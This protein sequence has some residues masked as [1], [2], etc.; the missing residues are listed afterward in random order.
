MPRDE[1]PALYLH[2]L[3][4]GAYSSIASTSLFDILA[5][6][7]DG[8]LWVGT[9]FASDAWQSVTT[10]RN[11]GS[12]WWRPEVGDGSVVRFS[13]GHGDLDAGGHWGPLRVVYLQYPSDPIVFF[14]PDM[15]WR[16]PVWLSGA[17]AEGVSSLLNWYPVVTFLQLALD[18]ALAQTTPIGFGHVYAPQDYFDGWVAVTGNGGLSA[19]EVASL[20]SLLSR[21]GERERI[22]GGWVRQNTAN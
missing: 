3:S 1:R 14:E 17:R 13:N 2:G 18:M 8:A 16:E 22:N 7:F 15:L 9:P 5:D 19:S 4:L 20:R 12:P 21:D 6:P 10:N 11:A